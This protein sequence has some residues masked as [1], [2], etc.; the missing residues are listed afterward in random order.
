VAD[1]AERPA[2]RSRRLSGGGDGVRR[3]TSA[4]FGV[5]TDALGKE[6]VVMRAGRLGALK[7]MQSPLAG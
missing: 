2:V 3:R 7:L 5:L 6:K 1:D 4:L